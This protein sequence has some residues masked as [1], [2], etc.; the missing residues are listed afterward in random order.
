MGK[1]YILD[2]TVSSQHNGIGT[3]VRQLAACCRKG[4]EVCIVS[5][6]APVREFTM[7]EKR[8]IRQMLFP[9]FPSGSFTEHGDIVRLFFKMY[10]TDT[11]ENLFI[12]NHSPCSDLLAEIKQAFPL[13]KIAF[14]IHDMGWTASLWGDEQR[15]R[16]I[17]KH[18]NRKQ[19]QKK[20]PFLL[21]RYEEE[22]KIY[23]TADRVVCLSADTKNLLNGL[24]GVE[25]EKIAL[26]PNGLKDRRRK[27][28]HTDELRKELLL[29]ADEQVLLFAGRPTLQKGMDTL[30]K[31]F[32]QI[33]MSHDNLRLVIA[34]SCFNATM[35]GLLRKYAPVSTRIV[36]TGLLDKEQLYK[37]YSVARI[38]ILPS[39]YEQCSYTG[40]EMM[41]HGLP[42]VTTNGYGIR[43]MFQEGVNAAVAPIG[44][45]RDNGGTANRLAQSIMRLLHSDELRSRLSAKSRQVYEQKYRLVCMKKR[46][47]D[48]L[49]DIQGNT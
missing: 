28:D 22:Q 15:Y 44:N 13:S 23:G 16:H 5:F 3:F 35:E 41:M 45:Y 27:E 9:P 31:A 33:A 29:S 12:V 37:W 39:Y 32:G 14:V 36:F 4:N 7:R 19:V 43:N 38:G 17:I 34:G 42:I 48:F 8:G 6:N 10:I 21:E 25:E 26:L 40:I 11:E 18:R 46:Y 30:L 1:I 24:Y 2:E 49:K 20:Y 47:R